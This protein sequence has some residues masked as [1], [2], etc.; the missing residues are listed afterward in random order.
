MVRILSDAAG[1]AAPWPEAGQAERPA[2]RS[3]NAHIQRAPRVDGKLVISR[4][5]S[6]STIDLLRMASPSDTSFRPKR[7]TRAR[8]TL[9]KVTHRLLVSPTVSINGKMK[10]TGSRPIGR[11]TKVNSF[12]AG[13]GR[14]STDL[15]LMCEGETESIRRSNPS[16]LP[17]TEFRL[18]LVKTRIRARMAHRRIIGPVED[19]PRSPTTHKSP[20]TIR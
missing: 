12:A 18:L 9:G 15:L 6:Q 17:A 4:R 16:D 5:L 13:G 14:C 11:G 1:L 8:I 20:Q 2:R 7:T 3:A 10:R 19:G